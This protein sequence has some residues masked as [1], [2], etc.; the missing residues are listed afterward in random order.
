MKYLV[1]GLAVAGPMLV[2]CRWTVKP[3]IE[4]TS[5]TNEINLGSSL[6]SVL[7]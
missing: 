4:R 6:T 1:L 5:K 3:D 7:P 2:S